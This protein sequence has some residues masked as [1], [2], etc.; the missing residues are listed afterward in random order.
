LGIEGA[1]IV[2]SNHLENVADA[3]LLEVHPSSLKK[4]EGVSPHS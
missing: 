4:L 1:H 2:Q 3:P